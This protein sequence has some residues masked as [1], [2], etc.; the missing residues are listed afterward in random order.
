LILLVNILA[1]GKE[2]LSSLPQIVE[3]PRFATMLLLAVF[4]GPVAGAETPVTVLVD[5][6]NSSQAA[7][8]AA[9]ADARGEL[10]AMFKTDQGQRKLMTEVEKKHGQNSPEMR[11]LWEKQ[12][13]ADA[14]NIVRLES[15]IAQHG[16]PR[17]SVFGETAAS[18][19]FFILQHADLSY[20]KKYLMKAREAA[21][22]KEMNGSHLALLEDRILIRE[23]KK[24]I[25]G[26]Q[27]RRNEAGDWEVLPLEDEANVDLRRATVGLKPLAEYLQGFADRGGGKIADPKND[28]PIFDA[29]PLT[30][31]FFAE[32]DDATVAYRKL[33]VLPPQR[34]E[35]GVA[36]QLA[37]R[38]FCAR[39]PASS[40]YGAVRLLAANYSGWLDEASR[41][42]MAGW[43]PDAGAVDPQLSP[44]QRARVALIAVSNKSQRKV[45]DRFLDADARLDLFA[46]ALAPHRQTEA[47]KEGLISAALNASPA[48]GIARLRENYPN[49]ASVAS[50]IAALEGMGQPCDLQFKSAEGG[51]FDLQALKGKVVSVVF[52]G[53][54][55]DNEWSH[56][57]LRDLKAIEAARGSKDFAVVLVSMAGVRNDVSTLIETNAITW[58]V[59]FDSKGW[60]NMIAERFQVKIA[61]YYLLVDRQGVLRFRG[62]G[63]S[64]DE[65]KARVEMLIA[66]K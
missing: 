6:S 45:V 10:E 39:F 61:P 34:G 17:R 41:A 58:P 18:A 42:R 63:P 5:E 11:A 27:V 35:A 19:A 54:N 55:V 65:T 2:R 12:Q 9:V 36:F 32:T 24:Q 52:L 62:L 13:E 57:L 8:D 20:Q 40:S 51:A 29:P 50:A 49:D 4:C 28:L 66:E 56:K 48:K 53:S 14:H 25:Y 37:C 44:E 60:K 21:L 46:T 31:Q 38:D 26:S 64:D 7:S 43:D 1:L 33:K 47:A 22:T 16:W 23:N 3:S 15:I 59:Y 30:Q